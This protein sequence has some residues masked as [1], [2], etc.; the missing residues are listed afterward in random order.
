MQSSSQSSEVFKS[1]LRSPLFVG[2][3]WFICSFLISEA[4][5]RLQAYVNSNELN[6]VLF[7]VSEAFAF[8]GPYVYNQIADERL[9]KG[10]DLFRTEYPGEALANLDTELSDLSFEQRW[11]LEEDL[12][13]K[14]YAV[15]VSET[16]LY[17][18]YIGSCAFT[19][20]LLGFIVFLLTGN[21]RS[22]AVDRD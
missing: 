14:G 19:G 3:T 15:S 20:F 22:S 8:P 9:Q 7:Q 18:I 13:D 11:D 1:K 10:I 21:R 2:L 17:A 5:Y 12:N 6:D 4:C 16:E